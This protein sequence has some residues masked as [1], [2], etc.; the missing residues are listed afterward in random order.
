MGQIVPEREEK[1]KRQIKIVY[2]ANKT[3]F[4]AK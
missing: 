2:L 3:S 1:F 4:S